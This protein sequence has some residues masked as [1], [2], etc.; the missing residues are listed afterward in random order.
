MRKLGALDVYESIEKMDESK[1]IEDVVKGLGKLP[2]LPGIA[3][4]ILEAVGKEQTSLKEIA[5]ILSTDPPLSVE[6]LKA[7]NSPL[8]GL[9]T[10]ITSVPHAV[11]LLGISTVKSLALS[12]SLVKN[13]QYQESGQFNHT[14]F[15]KDSLI[16][17]VSTKLIAEKVR[18]DF[19]ED[20]FFL[21]LLQDIGTLTLINIMPK[22][23]SLVMTEI[24]K[25]G[26][27]YQEAES[28]IL[29]FNH[30]EI[31]EYL[32][33]LWG[34]PDTFYT[35]IGYHHRPEKLVTTDS[36]IQMLTKILHLSSLFIEMF[37][38]STMSLNLGLIDHLVKNYGFADKINVNEIGHA[39]NRQT[40]HSFALFDID[41]DEEKNYDE[42]LDAAQAELANLSKEMVNEL[43]EKRCEIESLK[44]QVA[45]DSMTKLIN[46]QHFNELLE[47]EISRSERYNRPL[48]IIIADID[49]F[50][51]INDT[52]GHPVGDFVIKTVADSFRSE[53]RES[54]HVAR[55]GGDEFAVILP[56]T[57]LD[58]ALSAAEKL[59]EAI[60]SLK[61]VC[62]NKDIFV[63]ISF[64]VSAIPT[65][66]NI[67]REE[68]KKRAD[69][70]LYE[71]KKQ[72][73]N[74]CCIF[75]LN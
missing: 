37:N 38:S 54:D 75:E 30:M 48:S 71:A 15:W 51:S 57:P 73:R 64:G 59:R 49:H 25:N 41:L 35:S 14:N 58:S 52:F 33:K 67:S 10:K 1:M 42:L 44:R 23:Y 13:L 56:E 21:G 69:T 12:F 45:Q 22:Q 43:L 40:Q 72:G 63:T 16:G 46:H 18:P 4:R 39:I 5:D 7:T 3:M 62:D 8:Y 32:M 61:V 53:L 31:G 9:P 66:H 2:T 27:T 74:R 47:Q 17:A 20:A 65:T 68:L 50:K 34:L 24:E 6:V 11:N 60:E 55:Y 28:Q 70:A 29:G 19:S 36:D 26:R